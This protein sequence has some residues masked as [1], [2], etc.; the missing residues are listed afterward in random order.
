MHDPQESHEIQYWISDLGESKILQPGR[1]FREETN[2]NRSYGAVELRAPE[3]AGSAGWTTLAEVFSFGVIACKLLDIRQSAYD[4][5]PSTTFLTS[6]QSQSP[7]TVEI[8]DARTDAH[9][10]PTKLKKVLSACLRRDA[11]RRPGMNKATTYLDDISDELMSA[12]P[13]RDRSQ[14][15]CTYWDWNKALARAQSGSRSLATTPQDRSRGP[16]PI[17]SIERQFV[18]LTKGLDL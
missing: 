3:V 8:A 11:T 10:V 12:R 6:V 4:E 14:V 2:A 18:E 17:D 7:Q 1:E 15:E 13:E 5:T 9:I 16:L